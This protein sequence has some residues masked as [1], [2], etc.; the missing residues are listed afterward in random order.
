MD[1]N[2]DTAS[3]SRKKKP[4]H[5][6]L[7]SDRDPSVCLF[8]TVLLPSTPTSPQTSAEPSDAR[9]TLAGSR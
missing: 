3:T 5:Q 7:Q 9:S 6:D 1:H 4:P 2:N 8:H